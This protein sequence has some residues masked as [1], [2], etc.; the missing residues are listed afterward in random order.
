M[1]TLRP[2]EVVTVERNIAAGE[3]FCRWVQA[4]GFSRLARSLGTS[5]IVVHTWTRNAARPDWQHLQ[6][7]I[8]LSTIEPLGDGPL[9]Y[10]DILGEVRIASRETRTEATEVSGPH[11]DFCRR[12]MNF[13]LPAW[14]EI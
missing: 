9:T 13:N 6:A 10:E 2:Y 3:R 12:L 5:R 1:A 7:M 4:Y 8:A 14:G 11:R